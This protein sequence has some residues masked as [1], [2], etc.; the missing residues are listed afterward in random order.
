[1]G[2]NRGLSATPYG[3]TLTLLF[4]GLLSRLGFAEPRQCALLRDLQRRPLT[5]FPFLDYALRD[6]QQGGR[7]GLC[8]AE[9]L[10][11]VF[12]LIGEHQ[13]Q[14]LPVSNTLSQMLCTLSSISLGSSIPVSVTRIA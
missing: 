14:K 2:D 9:A 5:G 10:A 4:V 13:I 3:R 1:M 8:Q 6:T 7:P 11:L 12:D